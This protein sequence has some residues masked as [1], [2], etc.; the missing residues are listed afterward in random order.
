L[1]P[2][3]ELHTIDSLVKWWENRTVPLTQCGIRGLLEI[4][5]YI[6]P[7]TWNNQE[8]EQKG[9]EH[10]ETWRSRKLTGSYRY[11]YVDVVYLKRSWDDEVQNVSVLVAIGVNEDGYREIIGAAEGMKEDRES[12]KSST[13]EFNYHKLGHL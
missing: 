8:S 2:P 12:W 4:L 3:Q 11:V 7:Y 1:T 6:S 10:L 9:F 5:D 13:L